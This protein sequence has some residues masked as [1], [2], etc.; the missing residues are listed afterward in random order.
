[1]GTPLLSNIPRV[2]PLYA[3]VPPWREK[4][5]RQ[6]GQAC[7]YPDG[8]FC[9]WPSGQAVVPFNDPET[10]M[11]HLCLAHAALL[12]SRRRRWLEILRRYISWY[13]IKRF[14]AAPCGPQV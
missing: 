10:G 14:N 4:G 2:P 9:P 6:E 13:A 12:P 3:M 1:M 7:D 11:P 5:N 8:E